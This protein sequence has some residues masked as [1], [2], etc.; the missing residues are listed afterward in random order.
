MTR[1]RYVL[2]LLAGVAATASSG[3]WAAQGP[4]TYKG[5]E[6]VVAGVE[7]TTNVSL[8]DCPAGA[9]IVRGV[10]RPGDMREFVAVTVN[11]KVLPG[12]TPAMIPKPVLYDESGTAYNT[13]QTFAEIGGEPA[14]ACTFSFR[15]PKGTKVK[16]FAIDT[17]SIDLGA[18][19]Q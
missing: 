5:L 18:M 10:I 6:V 19:G 15:V 1:T 13:A 11:F 16:R 7:R 17:L 12:F 4:Q 8:A 2:L 3:V 9:N 14:F